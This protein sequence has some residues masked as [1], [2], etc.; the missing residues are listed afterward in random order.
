MN[1]AATPNARPAA[2]HG[3]ESIKETF[4]SIA[5]AFILAFVFRAFV[6]EAFVIPTGSMAPTLLGAHMRVHCE[7]CGFRFASDVPNRAGEQETP[8]PLEHSTSF[9]C[10]MC[11][12]DNTLFEGAKP[13]SGDRILVQK[14]VYSLRPPQRWD[15]AVFKNPQQPEVNFIK[16]LVGLPDEALHIFEG[17]IYV[18]PLDADDR[19]VADAWRV[20]RK[21]DRPEVQRAVWQPIYHSQYI[22][23]DQG[24]PVLNERRSARWQ[25][26]WVAQGPNRDHWQIDHRRSYRFDSE[27][28]GRIAFDFTRGG[29]DE[30]A[31]L[32]PYNQYRS[33][34]DEPIEDIRLAV[35]VA[36]DQPGLNLALTTSARLHDADHQD[37]EVGAERLIVTLDETGLLRLLAADLATGDVRD[38]LARTQL[39]PLAPG[40][41]TRLEFWF[42]D[43]EASVWIDGR[44][45]LTHPFDVAMSV[46][47]NR[48]APLD[49]PENL[50]IDVSG[51]PVTLHRIE[52]DRDIY[53]SGSNRQEGQA[54]GALIRGSDHHVAGDPLILYADEFFAVGDNGP[55]SA[56]GRYWSKV[57]AAIAERYF[58][59]RLEAG[60]DPA[61]LVP[62]ELLM[63]RAFFVY[64]PAP[65]PWQ[66]G[67]RQV[68]PNF[69]DMRIIR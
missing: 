35:G 13:S 33:W 45:V 24:E 21:S 14:Y 69:G 8:G 52:L 66:A 1:D 3:E 50:G 7:Q 39:D 4:E 27:R 5:I 10:P 65:Y 53:Y 44:R 58:A 19:P 68:V 57:D 9:V 37:P 32:Y 22:P 18:A 51:S 43:H 2:R 42:V 36:P 29:D 55:A 41:T 47:R 40:R 64:F 60:L 67:G 11:R 20:A 15:V 28:P 48:P 23:L 61:G 16:R 17:N 46:I 54:R 62:R 6:V 38:E 31:G 59:H 25:T 12:F 30:V 26:P 34:I 56:D 49:R 63:G